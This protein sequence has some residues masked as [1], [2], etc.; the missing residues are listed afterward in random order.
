L[1]LVGPAFGLKG[2]VKVKPFSGEIEHFFN[3][4]EVTLRQAGKDETWELA[5]TALQGN[6]LLIRFAGIDSPEAAANL[7]GAEIIVGRKLASPL[8]EGEFYVEDLKGLEV[9][10]RDG[11]I[12]G[13]ITDVIEGGGGNL[14]ELKLLSGEIRLAPFRNEFFGDVDLENGKIVLLESWILDQ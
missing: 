3:L 12:L 10:G 5:E 9:I 4:H 13:Y 2:F 1:G 14:V 6:S 7:K 11:E 8:K